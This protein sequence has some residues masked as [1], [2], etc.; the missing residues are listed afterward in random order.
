M[1]LY[2]NKTAIRQNGD[3]KRY[4][5][6]AH[7]KIFGYSIY[8]TGLISNHA[9]DCPSGWV[10][11]GLVYITSG[12]HNMQVSACKYKCKY[13]LAQFYLKILELLKITTNN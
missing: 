3:V 10:G 8:I 12:F 11:Y 1:L 4:G 5:L 6:P 13:L 7:I 9:D 2:C